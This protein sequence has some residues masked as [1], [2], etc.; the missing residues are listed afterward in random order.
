MPEDEGRTDDEENPQDFGAENFCDFTVFISKKGNEKV[1]L[2]FDCSSV[3]TEISI[4]N[5]QY[6]E[7]MEKLKKMNRF[8]R[9]FEMYAGPDFNSLDERLQTGITEYL[10]GYGVNEHLAAFVELQS[11][12]KDQRLYMTWLKDVKDF[13][14]D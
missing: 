9:G 7:D 6:T 2:I 12:D 1:G 13:L 14:K 5:I 8:D 3:E 11:L 4:N 10:Q